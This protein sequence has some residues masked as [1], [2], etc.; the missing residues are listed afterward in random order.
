L[1]LPS[2]GDGNAARVR[3]GLPIYDEESEDEDD[4]RD[5]KEEDCLIEVI[6]DGKDDEISLEAGDKF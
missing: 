4:Y 2:D 3:Q 1:D 5:L 6:R